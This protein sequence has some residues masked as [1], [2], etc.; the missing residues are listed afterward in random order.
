MLKSPLSSGEV[1]S[2]DRG[3]EKGMGDKV[4]QFSV[5][6]RSVDLFGV[7]GGQA[8]IFRKVWGYVS[9]YR[10]NNDSR[11]LPLGMV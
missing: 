11:H 8:T 4:Q 6:R 9:R 10:Q 1:C 2:P 7:E 3:R 5:N